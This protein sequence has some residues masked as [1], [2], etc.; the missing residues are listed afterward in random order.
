MARRRSGR[1]RGPPHPTRPSK[2]SDSGMCS[3]PRRSLPA[4]AARSTTPGPLGTSPL[5]SRPSCPG[6]STLPRATS[7]R[8]I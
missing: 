2:R 4:V 1:Q 8:P 5:Q 7:Q 3:D 6:A